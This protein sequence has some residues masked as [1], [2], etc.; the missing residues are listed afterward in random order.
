MLK[1]GITGGIGSGKSTVCGILESLGIPVY[2]A[3]AQSKLLYYKPGIRQQVIDL[4]GLQSYFEDGEPDKG[5]ISERV[6]ADKKLLKQL[7]AILHPAVQ[8]DFEEWVSKLSSNSPYI[9]KE[10]ALLFEAG[11]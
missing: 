8:S 5:F 11:T 7:E 4:L 10:A 3:D 2:Y 1:V 6:F 9:A